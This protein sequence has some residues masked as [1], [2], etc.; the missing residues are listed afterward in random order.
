[1]TRYL[2]H[3]MTTDP[4]VLGIKTADSTPQSHGALTE[5]KSPLLPYQQR[6]VAEHS[7]CV[8]RLRKLQ[9]FIAN[10]DGPF[11]FLSDA[12]QRR[13][14]RQEELMN[15]LGIVLAERVA[16]FTQGARCIG[17]E[18]HTTPTAN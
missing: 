4:R 12:E 6:V 17:C 18:V 15:E 2:M 11:R 7:E 14:V 3:P 8:N 10:T 13:L 16:A 5:G 9:A 1:M